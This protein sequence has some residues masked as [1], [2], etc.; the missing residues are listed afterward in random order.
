MTAHRRRASIKRFLDTALIVLASPFVVVAIGASALA[1]RVSMG[2]PV[3]FVQQRIGLGEQRFRVLKFRTM[4]SARD[5]DG[6]LLPDRSRITRTGRILRKLSLDELPQLINVLRGEMALV[7]P[8]PLL[9][10]YLPHYRGRERLRHSVRPGI[11][12]AAQIAGRNGLQWDVRLRMDADYAEFGTLLDDARIIVTTIKNVF[13]A[14]GVS[15]VAGDSGERL[16]VTRSYPNDGVYSLRRLEL[17]DAETRVA[18]FSDPRTSAHMN[19]PTGVTVEGTRAWIL[20]SRQ[21]PG[22]KDL[23]LQ[24]VTTGRLCAML[25]TRSD[26]DLTLVEV[27]MLVDPD[28]HAQ[29]LG[30]TSM[31]LL[32]EWLR[33]S[34]SVRGCWLTVDPDNRAAVRLYTRFGFQAVGQPTPDRLRM[35]LRWGASDD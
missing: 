23:V 9:V 19:V 4:S 31:R 11:T 22:R 13:L 26:D 33:N 16:D 32:L 1:V 18:W 25:G 7:G 5:N 20:K 30:S 14:D 12:G 27:H 3:F 35:E 15:V 24:E 29:G 10:E 6:E 21:S 8:R 17:A 28:R 2:T 34:P